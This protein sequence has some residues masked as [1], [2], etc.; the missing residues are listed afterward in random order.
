MTKANKQGK[1][2]GNTRGRPRESQEPQD[3]KDKTEAIVKP[4][5]HKT[6]KKARQDICYCKLE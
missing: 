4:R 1:T 5:N 2:Q 6:L 3:T